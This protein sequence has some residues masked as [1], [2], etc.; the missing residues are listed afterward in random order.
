[1]CSLVRTAAPILLVCEMGTGWGGLPPR[2]TTW[3][4]HRGGHEKEGQ[5]CLVID[6]RG[7]RERGVKDK[8]CLGLEMQ[9]CHPREEGQRSA[10][11]TS[12]PVPPS[13]REA[14]SS[15]G[16][17]RACIVEKKYKKRFLFFFFPLGQ[18]WMEIKIFP[19]LYSIT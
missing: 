5:L 3:Q 1:M 18:G 7:V 11:R 17:F 2:V 8:P 13:Q 16:H 4:V 10:P 19:P 12:A 15:Q 6:W 9:W 14:H